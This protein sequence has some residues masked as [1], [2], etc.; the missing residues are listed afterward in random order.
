MVV[1]GL[2]DSKPSTAAILNDGHIVS[3][4]SEER[5]CRMKM[6]NGMPRQAITAVMQQAGVAAG[7]INCVAVAQKALPFRPEPEPWEG[8]FQ[9]PSGRKNHWLYGLGSSLAPL[10]GS[11]PPAWRA[12][13]SLKRLSS[14]G[15][16]SKLP[17]MLREAYGINAP[18]Q[19]YDHHLCH[20]TSAYYTSNFERALVVTLDGGGDGRSGSIYV[21]EKGRL[22]P[23]ASVDSFNSLGNLY[24]YVTALCGFKAER[25]EGK[26]TGLAAFGEPRYAEILSQ[27]IRYEEPGQIRYLTPMYHR[28]A[29]RQLRLRLPKDF[30]RAHLA[31]SVQ[32][33]LEDIGTAFIRFWLR[34]TGLRHVAV[35]GGVFSNV[36]FNQRVN[37]LEEVEGFFVHPA[38][39]DSGL[40]VGGALA[41][42]AEVPGAD[43]MALIRTL[44]GVYLGPEYSDHDIMLAMRAAGVETHASH[45]SDIHTRIAELLADGAVVAR[46]VGRMEY[47]PRALGHRSIM[48]KTSEPSINEWLNKNLQR[49]EFMPFAP[50]TL[51]E[52][53]DRC[54][55]NLN[56]AMDPAR[57]MTVTFDCTPYMRETSPGVVHVDGTAR[58]QLIDCKTAP[59]FYGILT[60]YHRITG[61][62]SLINTSFNMHEEPIVC[63]PQDAIRAYQLGRLDYL[64]IGNWLLGT[65]D[66]VRKN[67]TPHRSR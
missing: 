39:D 17:A 27:M 3:A 24:S 29:L 51:V 7:D 14:R 47:G 49:T 58:P 10:V 40:A 23:L 4:I 15:R 28:S 16:L 64:A 20:A 50:A 48:Y 21:G 30:D 13:H 67:Q 57:F 56:G 37:E 44:P 31:A 11:L 34:K 65:P 2:I 5:L 18:V 6:A 9:E 8:W 53:A 43:P 19:F 35:A 42:L 60:A 33:V 26:I 12:Y 46:V 45:E 25:H 22:Y 38:M 1:L 61:V 54:Y 63:T 59:D 66:T 62:P 41:A 52:H 55:K 32:K 36:K